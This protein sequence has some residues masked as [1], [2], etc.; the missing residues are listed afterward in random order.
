VARAGIQSRAELLVALAPL[1]DHGRG[2]P[3]GDR[4][5]EHRGLGHGESLQKP[6]YAFEGETGQIPVPE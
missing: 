5:R 6:G 4:G 2:D 1:V 3:G